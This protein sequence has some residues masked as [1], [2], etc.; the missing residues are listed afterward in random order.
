ML[1]FEVSHRF[2]LLVVDFALIFKVSDK[3]V[4]PGKLFLRITR[5]N[6]HRRKVDIIFLNVHREEFIHF[7]RKPQ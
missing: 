5:L 6:L 7:Q 2:G 4:N 3:A 1:P